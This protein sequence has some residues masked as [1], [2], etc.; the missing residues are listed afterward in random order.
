MEAQSGD[1][2]PGGQP[3]A[4]LGAVDATSILPYFLKEM[5]RQDRSTSVPR[6]QTVGRGRR[7]VRIPS[8]N[9]GQPG[10]QSRPHVEGRRAPSTALPL[11]NAQTWRKVDENSVKGEWLA[12][13]LDSIVKSSD[14][15]PLLNHLRLLTSRLF[16]E[17]QWLKA[18]VQQKANGTRQNVQ[19]GRQ[20]PRQKAHEQ[21]AA[22]LMRR[23][24]E[25]NSYLQSFI[26]SNAR[27]LQSSELAKAQK[28]RA[29]ALESN[30]RLEKQAERDRQVIVELELKSRTFAD[31]CAWLTSHA[32][33]IHAK[34]APALV[35]LW[36]ARVATA[37]A[38][39]KGSVV[40]EFTKDLARAYAVA[41]SEGDAE[42]CS[43]DGSDKKMRE[44]RL[45]AAEL[46][47]AEAVSEA[48][49]A[50]TQALLAEKRA[51]V[52]EQRLSA[53]QTEL[54]EL[55]RVIRE[56][57]ST[58]NSASHSATDGEQKLSAALI[59]SQ[60]RAELAEEECSKLRG[61]LEELQSALDAAASEKNS[62]EKET[63]N[64]LLA[65][66]TKLST[67]SAHHAEAIEQLQAKHAQEI[68]AM[69]CSARE[70]TQ[71]R[72]EVEDMHQ[73]C[74]ELSSKLAATNAKA[75]E[76][77]AKALSPQSIGSPTA[78]DI[79]TLTSERD[80]YKAMA[81]RLEMD[82]KRLHAKAAEVA[83]LEK[84]VAALNAKLL[85][86]EELKKAYEN[87][88]SETQRL[89]SKVG[90][91]KVA[92]N[93]ITGPKTE[94]TISDNAALTKERDC[95]NARII[96]LEEQVG[97]LQK[98]N[99][100]LRN[101]V[102]G[103][104][105]ASC[106]ALE[107]NGSVGPVPTSDKFSEMSE[108]RDILKTRVRLLEEQLA[109]VNSSVKSPTQ[110]SSESKCTSPS[111]SSSETVKSSQSN[112][113]QPPVPKRSLGLF[114]AD[115]TLN[116]DTYIP[117]EEVGANRP[118]R[119]SELRP[120]KARIGVF[121]AGMSEGLP[122]ATQSSADTVPPETKCSAE[123]ALPKKVV[124][125]MSGKTLPSGEPKTPTKG[126]PAETARRRGS[127]VL[128][129]QSGDE[130]S[131]L[132]YSGPPA[133]RK[134][135]SALPP[136]PV[137]ASVAKP[138]Q[139]T[140]ARRQSQHSADSEV[141]G[142]SPKTIGLSEGK[143]LPKTLPME[144]MKATLS[145][146]SLQGSTTVEEQAVVEAE[147][148]PSMQLGPAVGKKS[149]GTLQ[150]SIPS[151]L[152]ANSV[153]S[154]KANGIA[155]GPATCATTASSA[156]AKGP[157]A[158][159]KEAKISSV[160]VT[161]RPTE[162]TKVPAPPK[163]APPVESAM[164]P[165]EIFS[166]EAKERLER[167][168]ADLRKQVAAGEELKAAN[169][170][171]Q[172]ENEELQ[173]RL[174]AA[175]GTSKRPGPSSEG[176][177]CVELPDSAPSASSG[178]YADVVKQRDSLSEK[179]KT[180]EQ[181]LLNI[182]DAHKAPSSSSESREEAGPATKM[183]LSRKDAS[184]SSITLRKAPAQEVST[185]GEE[186]AA[187]TAQAQANLDSLE[188][189]VTMLR[190]QLLALQKLK[191]ENAALTEEAEKLR[192]ENAMLK[193][194]IEELKALPEIG[195]RASSSRGAP[196]TADGTVE[197]TKDRESLNRQ[198]IAVEEE[199]AAPRTVAQNY[200][201]ER[202]EP[203]ATAD[204]KSSAGRLPVPHTKRP[205]SPMSKPLKALSVTTNDQGTSIQD[206]ATEQV[207]PKALERLT[208]EVKPQALPPKVAKT[209]P[210]ASQTKNA[211][212]GAEAG[213]LLSKRVSH[214]VTKKLAG[215][216]QSKNA[217][218]SSPTPSPE[219]T[220]SAPEPAAEAEDAKPGGLE[221]SSGA[222][223]PEGIPADAKA[224]GLE[225]SSGAFL[226]EEIPAKGPPVASSPE[227][228]HASS[229]GKAESA[230]PK[231][232]GHSVGKASPAIPQS[233]VD[234]PLS[235][236]FTVSGGAEEHA[237]GATAST[238][239]A[240]AVKDEGAVATTEVK[241][242]SVGGPK[243]LPENTKVPAPPKKAPS[244]EPLLVPEGTQSESAQLRVA[245]LEAEVRT[246]KS[247]AEAAKKLEVEI[248]RMRREVLAG[249]EA[250]KANEI[251]QK[252]ME[253]LQRQLTELQ[254]RAQKCAE[255]GSGNALEE[256]DR[257]TLRASGDLQTVLKERDELR[258]RVRV[259]E[260][261]LVSTGAKTQSQMEPLLS[262]E[263]PPA[264]VPRE[265]LN[266]K[267]PTQLLRYPSKE[268]K[269]EVAK[270]KAG[271][272]VSA[273]I[274]TELRK[275]EED[276]KAKTAQLEEIRKESLEKDKI[277][278][279]KT[280]EVET[281]RA[282]L[283]TL[284][285]EKMDAIKD[286]V[287]LKK[288]LE[289]L[290]KEL[291]ALKKGGSASQVSPRQKM[292]TAAEE[293]AAVAGKAPKRTMSLTKRKPGL[294]PPA[295]KADRPDPPAAAASGT[296]EEK[297]EVP[298]LEPNDTE[299]GN[300]ATSHKE[301]PGRRPR[302]KVAARQKGDHTPGKMNGREV[303]SP[304]HRDPD[305]VEEEGK[306]TVAA[307]KVSPPKR[308]G[309]CAGKEATLEDGKPA[310][311][312]PSSQ[313]QIDSSARNITAPKK[314]AL[315]VLKSMENTKVPSMG[316]Y[317]M[318]ELEGSGAELTTE[319]K[320]KLE[321]EV[322]SLREQLAAA[323]ELRNLQ[324]TLQKEVETLRGQLR[325]QRAQEKATGT[326]KEADRHIT[327]GD[328]GKEGGLD[329]EEAE[330][331]RR[332]R[333]ALKERI[334]ALESELRT[335]RSS[336]AKGAPSTKPKG[337][338][339]LKSK[340]A[341]FA[342]PTKAHTGSN[343]EAK[344]GDESS[345]ALEGG[346]EVRPPTSLVDTEA[347]KKRPQDTKQHD[348]GALGTMHLDGIPD[349]ASLL[350]EEV[351]SKSDAETE[352]G[353]SGAE[354]SSAEEL[355]ADLTE[356]LHRA[357]RRIRNLVIKCNALVEME[358]ER[359]SLRRRL[360]SFQAKRETRNMDPS[361][362]GKDKGGMA[363]AKAMEGKSFV[364]KS[365]SAAALPASGIALEETDDINHGS[366]VET[367]LTTH[368]TSA[369]LD[370]HPES[371]WAKKYEGLKT[372][373]DKL[374]KAYKAQKVQIANLEEEEETTKERLEKLEQLYQETKEELEIATRPP[375]QHNEA[376]P[377][378]L[379][380]WFGG[381]GQDSKSPEEQ[382]LQARLGL[383]QRRLQKATAE[384][385]ALRS[386]LSRLR[387]PFTESLRGAKTREGEVAVDKPQE[388]ASQRPDHDAAGGGTSNRHL[389][390]GPAAG[391]SGLSVD[392]KDARMR[393]AEFQRQIE[394]KCLL[395]EEQKAEIAKLKAGGPVSA[396][397]AAELRKREE[398]LKAK[399]AQ[400]EEVRKES[401]EKDKIIK[402]KTQEVETL[403]AK[404][405][406][407]Q[408][409]KMDAIKDS[410]ALKKELEKL[411]KELEAL[412]KGGSASQVSPRQK[413][414]TAAEES[415]AVAGKA[416]KRTMSLTKRKPGLPPPAPKADRPDP[417]AAAAS[418]TSEEKKEVPNLEP[419]DTEEGKSATS[420]KEEPGKRPEGEFDKLN[421]TPEGDKRQKEKKSKISGAATNSQSESKRGKSPREEAKSTKK[422]KKTR[423]K[424]ASSDERSIPHSEAES[425]ANEADAN[426]TATA[427][428]TSGGWGFS[429]FG[430]SERT[431]PDASKDTSQPTTSSAPR[432]SLLELIVGT[433]TPVEASKDSDVP[434]LKLSTVDG[435]DDQS[436]DSSSDDEETD[437]GI[438][439]TVAGF[440]WGF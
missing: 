9:G 259:L 280:Q 28:E 339:P 403:R 4:A 190:Q 275:R 434:P 393:L 427:P 375:T 37:S 437:G 199:L 253:K 204:M 79:P 218:I 127:T 297:K 306:E 149:P 152:S 266:S 56:A 381:G 418:G 137:K 432:P 81:L 284:Q 187:A 268:Q 301:E 364:L 349:K 158:S 420:H 167:E 7:T 49:H 65:A 161:K 237:E 63:A 402:E 55:K 27:I 272:S 200:V 412:K 211:L 10:P 90:S 112:K 288:E 428:T 126:L 1:G 361:E 76:G 64:A 117:S 179:V 410:V 415:A 15:V 313:S 85:A 354:M 92:A 325:A 424:D 53:A 366:T 411:Q 166:K 238:G 21:E 377:A 18:Q 165:E 236:G 246:F 219:N 250:R 225:A 414:V 111:K 40:P 59:E 312:R 239:G 129:S 80:S 327:K 317:P 292:V 202:Q 321:K 302:D 93:G 43:E 407:L 263:P 145:A 283:E 86:G 116:S 230:L 114:S 294:P 186:S 135:P 340:P 196:M 74:A 386:E 205:P 57:P 148:V 68:E 293:S 69:K 26:T 153:V 78:S 107:T 359:D 421:E 295:P 429:L 291:E 290:Q 345:E 289:K 346:G 380:S 35:A 38:M 70:A 131:L 141:E 439:S 89:R 138:S 255:P 370:A 251:L 208:A 383:L 136:I 422:K 353:D 235:Q 177:D 332:E 396:D 270:L 201:D 264:D 256:R 398:D 274:A 164:L 215:G 244:V 97:N 180:L 170:T 389:E 435:A 224:G 431:S 66:E 254:T 162:A 143:E 304:R 132:K 269:A 376:E 183:P 147:A 100:S 282:K 203:K 209:G 299:E 20:Q 400:L 438:A 296:S 303:L 405:E 102:A 120:A 249:E 336:A 234:I 39:E 358:K 41:D 144:V 305:A 281:L 94:R 58:C 286:S 335:L 110:E 210:E 371:D 333:N 62:L 125:P 8:L 329:V 157:V 115:A 341:K 48:R 228:F 382:K 77:L 360:E 384:N 223:L 240:R 310:M 334:A 108:E 351:L 178:N 50:Q 440:F 195:A 213:T 401:L 276:L 323:D 362:E 130:A 172:R 192:K 324:N 88:Q 404:L 12:A 417:P 191:D 311:T 320:E 150:S 184:H 22:S 105:M 174:K 171:L 106:K 322:A 83:Q 379:L 25:E 285:K 61:H 425:A 314:G 217:A 154:G 397:I 181:E 34:D 104:K 67:L 241:A 248:E 51:T 47:E 395:I 408:K 13:S 226:P 308:I 315:S 42:T 212:P 146:P 193:K 5:Q 155:E 207:V 123:T 328:S 233:S 413:M 16:S 185:A 95:L 367:G 326:E 385:E 24:M 252:E 318:R 113:P 175:A 273:D 279:E 30:R 151:A 216:L 331:L 173:A 369:L 124:I 343:T 98:E 176:N 307:E 198:V 139:D 52:A 96:Y 19:Q 372:Q 433:E 99:E 2:A 159:V 363:V 227:R 257:E 267:E 430:N 232:L 122:A 392:I 387:A 374:Y 378:G 271:G 287:A 72:K 163:K 29:E 73:Q 319:L 14:A 44:A 31:A 388:S 36:R 262:T 423:K 265:S 409:E 45:M 206:E 46:R 33:M 82:I 247:K 391:S 373:R 119:V 188:Q 243:K 231:K 390:E 368:S 344:G 71:L 365:A 156:L 121:P 258:D 3:D 245:Q 309:S 142:A 54:K 75:G 260:E 419:N 277:I 221:A 347:A 60:K 128:V 300:S 406:T 84:T 133:S 182:V 197:V 416:P 298:N 169:E 160:G 352:D 357:K 338:P 229:K 348:S 11:Q 91:C 220:A 242:V 394:Q 101:Q 189:E 134:Q 6:E 168:M 214:A 355:V 350:T 17:N 337:A 316:A 426:G 23:I 140:S 399:T 356:R 103:F 118:S 342:I 222:V 109:A 194:Q 436:N 278:K 330:T 87:L 261:K 32:R